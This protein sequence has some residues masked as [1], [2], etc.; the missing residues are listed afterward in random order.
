MEIGIINTFSKEHYILIRNAFE[1]FSNNIEK[2]IS[3]NANINNKKNYCQSLSH[4]VVESISE[5]I[6]SFKETSYKENEDAPINNNDINQVIEYT[7]NLIIYIY[8]QSFY[9]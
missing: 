4:S 8:N 9:N 5:L 3:K 1:Y 7:I 6:I 2:N